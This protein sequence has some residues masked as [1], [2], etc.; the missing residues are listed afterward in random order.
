MLFVCFFSFYTYRCVLFIGSGLKNGMLKVSQIQLSH[1]VAAPILIGD[2]AQ[3]V[4]EVAK[5]LLLL[6]LYVSLSKEVTFLFL[7]CNEREQTGTH[8]SHHQEREGGREERRGGGKKEIRESTQRWKPKLS[9]FNPP[10]SFYCDRT[11]ETLSSI[12]LFSCI[13]N[14]ST[15]SS[16]I[17]SQGR[18]IHLPE[19]DFSTLHFVATTTSPAVLR[20]P[21]CSRMRL[22]VLCVPITSASIVC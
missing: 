12:S 20:H 2:C 19:A 15:F 13:F 10:L 8:Q 6:F 16:H 7:Q 14:P 21:A 11:G 1:A 17:R 18:P 22:F 3:V 5:M 4:L 9:L